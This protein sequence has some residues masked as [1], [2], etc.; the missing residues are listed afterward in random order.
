M[1]TKVWQRMEDEVWDQY[2]ELQ[3]LHEETP[4]RQHAWFPRSVLRLEKGQ[5]EPRYRNFIPPSSS[6]HVTCG[7]RMLMLTEREP[8]AY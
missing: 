6:H 1:A 8:A 5:P 2:R 3:A 7:M 4:N